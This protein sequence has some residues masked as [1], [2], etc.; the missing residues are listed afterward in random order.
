MAGDQQL[1]TNIAAKTLH[2]TTT[3]YITTK[4]TAVFFQFNIP[5]LYGTSVNIAKRAFI[6]ELIKM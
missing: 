1:K 2:I 4:V 3:G 5:V 6:H